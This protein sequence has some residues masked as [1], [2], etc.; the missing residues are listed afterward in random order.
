M[1]KKI[2]REEEAAIPA[3]KSRREAASWFLDKY[4]ADFVLQG[5]EDV[6]GENCHFYA[7][8]LDREAYD[9][10][11]KQLQRGG[12]VMGMDYIRAYQPIEIF[13]NGEI[14]IVH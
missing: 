9:E 13:E 11:R 7:L 14:H 4:S 3:F 2:T 8:I 10:G 6:G 5:S 1:A 12:H